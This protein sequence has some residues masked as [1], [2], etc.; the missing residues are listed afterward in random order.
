[1]K[2]SALVWGA[3]SILFWV[4]ERTVGRF[5]Q[6]VRL[7]FRDANLTGNARKFGCKTFYD[8][9]RSLIYPSITHCDQTSVSIRRDWVML[10]NKP[11]QNLYKWLKKCIPWSWYM[12]ISGHQEGSF[13]CYHW[14]I[15]ANSASCYSRGNTGGHHTDDYMVQLT[16]DSGHFHSIS[17]ARIGH[18]APLT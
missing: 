11:L 8:W 10:H 5:W 2:R 14:L 1:M 6:C 17:L 9:H 3:V 7:A 16:S 13:C 4:D 12:S 18:M 15:Q